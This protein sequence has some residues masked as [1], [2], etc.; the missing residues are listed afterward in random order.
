MGV[1]MIRTYK[2]KGKSV[3]VPDEGADKL[4]NTQLL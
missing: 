2:T 1:D 4:Q 3:S